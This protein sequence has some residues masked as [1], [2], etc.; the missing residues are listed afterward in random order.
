MSQ[1]IKWSRLGLSVLGLLLL[2]PVIYFEYWFVARALSSLLGAETALEPIGEG[3]RLIAT[4]LIFVQ[5]AAGL[6]ALEVADGV[7]L[8]AFSGALS[9]SE[10]TKHIA[11][12]AIVVL[13]SSSTI[14][15]VLLYFGGV[16]AFTVS[17]AAGILR[18]ET[19]LAEIYRFQ[20]ATTMLLGGM[21]FSC[22]IVAFTAL[23]LRSL[24]SAVLRPHQFE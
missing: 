8:L 9:R 16:P 11:L 1:S 15:A 20:P 18:D 17:D 12:A 4:F 10:S 24:I 5:V 14:A 19:D 7:G 2:L 21:F 13:F 23:P 6:F 3:A 22:L